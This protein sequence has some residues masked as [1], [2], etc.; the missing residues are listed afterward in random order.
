MP[1]PIQP[2]PLVERWSCHQCGVCCRGSI[3]PLSADDVARLKSQK[4]EERPEFQNTPVMVRESWL[5]HEYR[6]AQRE[7]GSCVFLLPDGLC[8][9]HKE[10]GFDAKPLVCRMFPLQIVPRDKVA[11]VTL[12]RACPSAAADKGRS[13]AEQLDFARKLARERHLADA[14]PNP[15]PIKPG[16]RREW[17]VARRLLE[18]IQRLLTDERYPP[19]RRLVHSLV[20]CRLLEKARTRS[21]SDEALIELIQVLEQSV[22]DEVGNVFSQRQRPSGAAAILFRQTAAEFVWLAPGFN[23]KPSWRKRWRLA[24]AAWKVVRGRGNLPRLHPAFP[25][26]TFEQL[27][28]PLGVLDPAIYQPLN[29][30]IETTAVSWSYALANRSGW[31]IVESLRMLSLTYPI[32]LWLLRWRSAGGTPQAECM[33]EITTALDRGQG[34]APLAGGKQRRRVQV[35]AR[36][37]E[38]ERLV[39]WYAR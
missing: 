34:Y 37:D 21:L 38:L 3:V 28:E 10:L 4:W 18:T 32:G 39:I 8:R 14:A 24:L 16:E 33:P 20:L 17:R 29:R 26:A 19:V 36:L 23:A 2:L 5:G 22:V 15:P 1:L 7:D 9:I 27:E 30:M 35:L 13:V 11:F 25:A 6:L 12:R 31:S